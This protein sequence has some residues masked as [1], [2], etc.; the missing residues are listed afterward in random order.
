MTDICH[1]DR[2]A[3]CELLPWYVNGTLSDAERR[4]MEQHLQSCKNC[5]EDIPLLT[6]VKAAM[7][8]ESVSVLAPRSSAEHLF[9]N[10]G[11]RGKHRFVWYATAV[12]AAAALLAIALNWTYTN[13]S[14]V[15]PATYETATAASGDATFDY[16]FSVSFRSDIAQTERGQALQRLA[17]VSVAGPDS[18]G[19]YRVVVRLP[20][21][22]MVE[23]ETFRKNMEADTSIT[24]ATVVAVELPVESP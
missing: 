17:P 8:R 5:R 22:S 1:E 21:R 3:Q 20:A 15:S 10:T 13:N 11:T 16:V 4:A 14:G 19:N 2:G 23:I 9:A 24:S 7:L 12:A 6:G 18:T